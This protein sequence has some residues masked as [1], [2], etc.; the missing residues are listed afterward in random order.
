MASISDLILKPI[1]K[2]H[3]SKKYLHANKTYNTA[4]QANI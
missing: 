3:K 4:F 2:Q 1:K